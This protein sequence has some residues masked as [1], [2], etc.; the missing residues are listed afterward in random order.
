MNNAK[1]DSNGRPI[2]EGSI[3]QGFDI[4]SAIEKYLKKYQIK[5]RST[6]KEKPSVKKEKEEVRK[7]YEKKR[8]KKQKKI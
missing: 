5:E 8:K 4:T 3:T 7:H 2:L 1:R 6:N